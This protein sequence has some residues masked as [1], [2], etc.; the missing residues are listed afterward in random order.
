[1]GD[2]HLR[3]KPPDMTDTLYPLSASSNDS[4]QSSRFMNKLRTRFK[5]SAPPRP[6][7]DGYVEFGEFRSERPGVKKVGTFA[8]VFCPVVLSMF[9]ALVFIRMGYLVGNAGL[10]VTLGQFGLAYLIVG[11]TVM[12]IC[13]ISTNGAVEGGGV[14]FMISRTLGPEFGG[15]IGTLFFFANVVSS[16]LCISAC[17]EALVE[18]FGPHGYLISG[19]PGLPDGYWYRF[20]YR[21]ALNAAG[22]SVSLAGASLF[23]RTSLAI[24]VTTVVCL[25]SAFLSFFITSP[26]L[27]EKPDTNHLVNATN[28]TYTGLSSETL[29]S[30]L[31]PEYARDYS[32]TD[33]DM[34]DFAS[35]FG[36][37]FTGVTGVMAG[38]NM[39]GELQSPA[40]SI[41]RGTLAALLFTGASYAALAALSAAS[42]GRALL[43]NNYVYLLPINV[44]PPF[45]AVGMLTATFSA[46]LSNLIGAS[47]VLEALAKDNIFGFI[48]RP[49]VSQ[50]GNPVLAVIASWL[51]V[52]LGIIADSLNTIAQVNSVLFMTS[53]FAINLACLGLDLASAPNFRPTFRHFSWLTS[54]LGLLGCA[55]LVFSLRPA[56]ACAVALACCSLVL[57]LHLLSPAAAEP[58]WGS[59]SQ[60]LIFHQVRKY[61]LLLDPRRE[62]VKFWRP[63][64]LLLIGSPRQSAPLIDFVNDQK[65]GGLFVIG[66]VRVGQLDGSGDPLADEQKYWLKLIDHLKVKAFVELCLA[67]SIRSGAAHLTRLSGLGAMKP[68]TVLL[69]FR[70]TA[71]PKDFFRDPSSPYKTQEFDLDSGQVVFP[72]RTSLS[73]RVSAAEYV[74]IVSDVLC[75]NKNV[76]LC[77][78]FH[79]LDMAAV[80]R[81]SA[82]LKYI[83]V[84]LV[85]PLAPSREEPF[86]VRALFALQ[87]AAVV[88]SAR[89]WQH[90]RLRVHVVAAH[91]QCQSVRV[92]ECSRC[93]SPPSCARRAAGSTCACACTSSPRTVSVRVSECQSVRVF[94]L[95]L[96]AVVRSARGWQHLRLRVHVVAAHG[97]CQSVRVSECSRCSSPPSCARRAAGST[98]AC[99]CTSSPR[100]VSVRVSE[101]QSVRVFALQLAAVVRSAR[102]WQHLRLRVHVVAAHGQCQSVRVSECSRCSSPPSCARRAAGSTCACACTSSP[103]TVSVRVSECQSV[104]AA[105]RR[106]RALG[107][108]LAAPA[109]ARARRRRA[110]SVSECQ[111]V[112]VFALQLA[113]VVRSA[114]GWQHLRLRVHVVAAHGQC[115]SVRVSEC[116]RCSSPPSCARRAAGSTCA[117]ACTSSPRTV[118]VRVSECQSVRV[119]ALQLAAVVRSARGWQHLRLRVHVVAAHARRRRALG[120]RLAAPAPARARRRRARSV[121]E[122]QSVRVFALQLAAVVRSARGWQHLRLRV[123]VVAAHGQCQSVRVS[124]CS[125]CSSPPSCARRA[126]G[127]TC[128]CACTSSPRTVSVRVSEC[129]SVRVFALQLAAV[130]RSARG[131]QHLRLRVHVVA[132]HGQ[133]QSVRVFALQLAAVV[134]SA[135]G[136]QHLRLRV[137]VVA[138]HGQCQSV[139]VSECS[140]CSS[141]PSCARRAAGSTCACACTS[142]PRTVSVRVSECQSVRA[143]ARRR[144]ALGARLAAPAPARARRRRARSVSECQ[145]VRVFALQLAAV[146]RS[147]RGWQHLRLRVHVVAAH[148]QCQSVRVSECQSV[149]AAAR[150]RR[151]L[152]ARLAAPAPARAR[153]RRARSVSECQSVRVF[154]LQLAAVVR[155]ARGWQ[156][157]RLRVHVVPA[158][159]QCQ[160]VRVSECSRC[161]SP[162]SCA[163]RAAGSTCACA[164]TSSPRTVSVRVS[165]CQSVRVFAL[166]L[167]AVVRSARG[168]QHLRL[169]VHVVAAHGQCQSVR[170]SEC[171]RC[172]SPPSCARR[173]AG[174]TCACACTSS[175]R[176]LAAVVRSARGWQH[177]RLRVHVVAAHGQCQS[178]R[179]SSVRV[180]ALQLA[181]V[182][183][184]ARGWQHLRLR[185]HVVAAHGQCQ[186][187]RVFALQLAAVVR[188]ARGWQHL[189]LR[190]HVVAAHARRRRALGAR[191]A[192]PA[193]ARARRRRARSVSECQSVRV[194]ALQLAAVV[195]SARGWQHLRLRVHVVAAHGQCQSVR[196]SECSRCSSPPSCARRAAGSTCA[197]A[198]T[199]SPR[200]VSVRVSECQSVRVFALQ[201]A[202]VVRSARGWQHLRLRV[203]VVAAHGQCQSVRVSECSR[204]SSPPSCARRAAGSTCACACTSSPRTVSVRVSECQSVRV[205]ALQLAAVVRSARGWQHLRLRVHVVAAHGQCQSVRVSECQSVRAA[206]RRRRALGARLAAP[207]PARAR[208]RRARSVSE[209]QSVRVFALQLAAVVRSARGWQH[210]RLRVHVV[211]AHG[212]CQ[213]VRVSECSRCS[214][215]PSCA[216]RA[217][218][219]TC[220]CA[221]TSSPRTVSVRVSECQSVSIIK[222]KSY[223]TVY[224]Y[225]YRSFPTYTSIKLQHQK[226]ENEKAYYKN[227]KLK[228][229][230]TLTDSGRSF[231]TESVPEAGLSS[232]SPGRPLQQRLDELLKMLRISAST[233][234]V[235]DWPKLDEDFHRW[236][237]T[238]LEENIVY[239]RV[240]MSYLQRVNRIIKSRCEEGTAVTFVQLPQPPKLSP[241]ST[242]D[243][244]ICDQ[245]LKVLDEF[246]KD[247]SPTILV[248]GLKSV[249]STSL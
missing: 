63:Q 88:R 209:C 125:R 20:L 131:W 163:R 2:I 205:F 137:H 164:C 179:V 167:A 203:H 184:S 153:R 55:A 178:V 207:A 244:A 113:A 73:P 195:R 62:H 92:S 84:W 208:R 206:A 148:G 89:G 188:S 168:W 120:A 95:Q 136:W 141:P 193:P 246:T 227:E 69:G 241:T 239:Q 47:R 118:S 190:V 134:R 204:C 243:E 33:G 30:N 181:A 11:F 109:P 101:C 235:N 71:N 112:R 225:P 122:C 249:T 100:T 116:S 106:R 234:I 217:A 13:A 68:D 182:V 228:I 35:V 105:A 108:R 103:R 197:C 132:A 64:M 176:T 232:L 94:A 202:A 17:T 7:G 54:L 77:R 74:R 119:F 38:A 171:S 183:R 192:A 242:E 191:L 75:V 175:P 143:A 12:S 80:E 248:R 29:R 245:Y 44:W 81:K 70:D 146:V 22:V 40:R 98:C 67:E 1:M 23:A 214:S 156:H 10:L 130:V 43:Q 87:L 16:A 177:L 25:F 144:R 78:H 36:V 180:F 226:N 50:S 58:K 186:S 157:L 123:H 129:Q 200:T 166:Q 37:L 222:N 237:E 142:S 187:V 151:A 53:Y 49:M 31:Y 159:G 34:V 91:G 230:M 107:A 135:R 83:D 211:A 52:Q 56:Y 218:G 6:P 145:S 220:A 45:I 154:A 147:A 19:S 28:F 96:A 213:S 124:E 160:S 8:G 90:L 172:S 76:C 155:S 139:R 198:C 221:C 161:S 110:R 111:S 212:Q 121:S 233:H 51:L 240:P 170:V 39:S 26:G 162:P 14:Y 9:S 82:A 140:R 219:S 158:H 48:L 59:L 238:S 61:L 128:A 32:T 196:V 236:S 117:C 165:E 185:V 126:A 169:R 3:T 86:T 102:G 115:Q 229:R 27:I 18:N 24:W 223:G 133:C 85:E 79:N 66:H 15:A 42:C 46:G 104:R 149:R 201:L 189:R 72:A 216:R 93:S 152:G 57:A 199:S 247:L 127:S 174:S 41:P 224:M 150:R 97:Q 194:F 65:K 173:A 138:A 4:T 210:L 21:S 5:R 215:P 114:R 99:A 231:S 60:A